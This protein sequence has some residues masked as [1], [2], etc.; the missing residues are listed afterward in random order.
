MTDDKQEAEL[1]QAVERI[2]DQ[3]TERDEGAPDEDEVLMEACVQVL[4]A[5]ALENPR[6]YGAWARRVGRELE[7]LMDGEFGPGFGPDLVVLVSALTEVAKNEPALALSR[8]EELAAALDRAEERRDALAEE[9]RRRLRVL[10][11]APLKALRIMVDDIERN[12]G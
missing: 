3:M 8:R 6:Y 12:F 4:G 10:E 9:L 2:R 11:D 7:A 1:R 5:E